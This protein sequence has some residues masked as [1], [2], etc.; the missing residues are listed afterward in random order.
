METIE[1]Y[2]ETME[3]ILGNNGKITWNLFNTL[4]QKYTHSFLYLACDGNTCFLG[5]HS[6][7]SNVSRV[8][9][10]RYPWCGYLAMINFMKSPRIIAL[11]RVWA[12]ENVLGTLLDAPR[13]APGCS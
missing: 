4:P 3:K 11:G 10:V 1:N 6:T 5:T 13:T 12:L 9:V 2:L 7:L 8:I